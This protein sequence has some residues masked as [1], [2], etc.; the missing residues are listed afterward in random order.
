VPREVASNPCHDVTCGFLEWLGVK[1]V[2]IA[3]GQFSEFPFRTVDHRTSVN[4][5]SLQQFCFSR[6]SCW[7]EVQRSAKSFRPQSD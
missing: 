1:P 7:L 5:R 6:F 4:A 3:C 2:V